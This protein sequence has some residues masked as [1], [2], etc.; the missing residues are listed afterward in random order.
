MFSQ[1]QFFK[2]SKYALKFKNPSINN[3]LKYHIRYT[4]TKNL[5][6]KNPEYNLETLMEQKDKQIDDLITEK[7]NLTTK[8]TTANKKNTDII[9]DCKYILTIMTFNCFMIFI[10]LL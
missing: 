1:K 9:D 5:I 6:D 8:L 10:V 2:L 4:N 7:N 3:N